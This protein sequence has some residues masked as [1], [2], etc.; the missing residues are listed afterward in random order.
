MA[1]ATFNSDNTS[2]ENVNSMD[3]ASLLKLYT[4]SRTASNLHS[5]RTAKSENHNNQCGIVPYMQISS[6]S[7]NFRTPV[8][9][10]RFG[11]HNPRL[12][13]APSQSDSL[14]FDI[15]PKEARAAPSCLSCSQRVKPE[16][17]S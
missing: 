4:H 13:A 5:V 7:V 16:A 10:R 9:I 14:S 8:R 1:A 12:Q 3:D 15:P 2:L 17:S 6:G 11:L